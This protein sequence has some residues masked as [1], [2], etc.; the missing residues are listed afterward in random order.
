MLQPKDHSDSHPVAK[1]RIS[2][3]LFISVSLYMFQ[4]V[5]VS[6]SSSSSQTATSS[7]DSLTP[8]VPEP[9]TGADYNVGNLS[10]NIEIFK[11]INALLDNSLDINNLTGFNVPADLT[12]PA[13]TK[14]GPAQMWLWGI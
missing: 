13:D 1:H 7:D 6:S 4:S 5:D 8:T 11:R 9:T 12:A 2:L 14:G 3:L 10:N